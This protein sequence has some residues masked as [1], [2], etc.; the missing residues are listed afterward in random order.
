MIPEKDVLNYVDSSLNDDL[1]L[2]EYEEFMNKQ[3]ENYH[4]YEKFIE[5]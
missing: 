4:I 5:Y 2:E 3:R 1:I